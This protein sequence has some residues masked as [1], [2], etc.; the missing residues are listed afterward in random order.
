[1]QSNYLV[2][3][4]RFLTS[5]YIKTNAFLYENFIDQGLSVAEFCQFEVEPI[6]KEC[7][8]VQTP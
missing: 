2:L 1:M 7:D 4:M 5:G 3:Y 6:D 8:Q